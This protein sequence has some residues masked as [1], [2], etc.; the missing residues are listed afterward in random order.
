M[1]HTGIRLAAQGR[2]EAMTPTLKAVW[3]QPVRAYMSH[4]L[5][6]VRPT[7][8]LAEVQ[9]IFKE[10]DISAV[11]VVQDEAL[12]GIVTTTDMLREARIE[13]S[14]PGLVTRVTPPPRAAGDLMRR[15]VLTIDEEAPLTLAA[16]KMVQ[17]RVHRL[18]VLRAKRPVG[19]VSARDAM[20]AV[21]EQR[22]AT[23]PGH[24]ICEDACAKMAR[25]QIRRTHR[26]CCKLPSAA[27]IVS[28]AGSFFA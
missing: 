6:S 15:D 26:S 9:R 8:P 4:G 21:L 11:P 23:P 17:H 10:R 7:T 13:V 28:Q 24:V 12:L 5:V 22:I 3:A 18:I 20:R 25:I 1:N 2:M 19:V 27:L 16:E 14:M